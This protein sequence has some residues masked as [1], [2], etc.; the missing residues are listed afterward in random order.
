MFGLALENKK[1]GSAFGLLNFLER[2]VSI[3]EYVQKISH[4][5][6]NVF[7]L[8]ICIPVEVRVE[9]S[10]CVLQLVNFL[11]FLAMSYNLLYS[12]FHICTFQR[13]NFQYKLKQINKLLFLIHY[14]V[15]ISDEENRVYTL[16]NM[17]LKRN[18]YTFSII[19]C[20]RT[21]KPIPPE[22]V[23]FTV[24]KGHYCAMGHCI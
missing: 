7:N 18:L 4:F 24:I 1:L 20:T 12:T 8:G 9:F 6:L 23:L 2:L 5:L 17:V 11:F 14:Q 15:F 16:S 19:L 21:H 22:R 3:A 10:C 13:I